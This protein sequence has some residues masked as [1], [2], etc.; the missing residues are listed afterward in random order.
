MDQN[1]KQNRLDREDYHIKNIRTI[2]PY[3]LNIKAKNR[4]SNGDTD[5]VGK[6]FPNLPRIKDR[7]TR[8]NR[9]RNNTKKSRVTME[10]FFNLVQDNI[11]ND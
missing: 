9:N 10:E 5:T 3:G 8:E 7:P 6:L 2:Y 4:F 11:K 1:V